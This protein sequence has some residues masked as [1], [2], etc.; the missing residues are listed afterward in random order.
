MRV[1]SLHVYPVKG[2]RGISL[3][4]FEIL[5]R[6]PRHDRR[7]M[8]LGEDDT[9]LTQRSHPKLALVETQ[10][11]DA[12][13][14]L[15]YE[16]NRVSVPLAPDGPRRQARVWDDDV[17]GLVTGFTEANAFF[18]DV[19]GEACTLVAMPE[20]AERPVEAA[21]ANADDRV[22][23]ADG[24]PVLLGALAS[25]AALNEALA[26][27]DAA[28]VGMDRFRPNVVVDGGAA[29]DEDRFRRVRIG[30]VE[31]RMPKRCARCAV[32]TVDQATGI[33]SKE[34]L[35]TLASFR[36]EANKVY[37]AQNLIPDLDAG[38]RAVIAVGDEVVYH[39]PNEA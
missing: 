18:S 28:P 31:L 9:F 19:L 13:L 32:T 3:P 20:D 1:A 35:K 36:T 2:C 29:W 25:L 10:L 21:F 22:S 12:E 23:F 24:Y 16:G 34:P 30:K 17:D 7:F 6:G 8:V 39:H 37:F 33:A 5:R 26:K 4:R 38:V 15:R 11:G 27:N 14:S